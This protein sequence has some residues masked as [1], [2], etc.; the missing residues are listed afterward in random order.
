M[1]NFNTPNVRNGEIFG[2]VRPNIDAHTLGIAAVAKLIEEC[3]YKVFTG[4]A[5]ITRAVTHISK[6]DNISLLKKWIQDHNITRLGFSYRLDPVNAEFY[7][8][9]FVY[10][11]NSHNLFK[12][13]GGT[14]IQIYFAGLPDACMRIQKLYRNTI[15]VFIGDETPIESLKKLGV[16]EAKIPKSISEG[17]QY[18]EDRFSF[19]TELIQKGNYKAQKPVI[20]SG[21]PSY[22]T[23]RDTLVER[24]FHNRR[25][26]NPPLIR[27]H[28]G[29]YN[30]NYED[31]KKEF[32]S[33]LNTLALTGFLDIVSVGSSQLS[34]SHFGMEWGDRANG[35]GVPVNS[36][37]DYHE[38]WESS[39]PMLVRTYSS[40]RNVPD[41][42]PVYERT[43][44]M[45]WHAL[46]FWWFNRI[47][48]R[49]PNE[50]LE[51]LKQHFAAIQRI[52][53]FNK[54]FEPN[55]PHHFS[56]RG[57]DDY[58]YVLSSYIAAK[59]AKKLGIKWFVLQTMLNTP[60]HTWGVQ[61]LA[62]AR[63]LLQ[64]C[65]E[66]EDKNFKVFHQPRAGLDYFS[67]DL[68][69]AKIQLA[70]VTA[71]M[72]D[73]EPENIN[74]PDIIHVVSYCEAVK[75]ATPD[76]IN[77]SIQ[78]TLN[79]LKEYRKL[80]ISGKMSTMVYNKE[81]EGR[82]LDL[83]QEVKCTI[84]ILEK[85]IPNLYTPEG[86]YEIFKKGVFAVPYL[87]EGRD[88]F[89]DAIQWKTGIVKGAIHVL[90]ENGFPLKPKDRLPNLFTM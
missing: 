80:K 51:N 27:V 52:A 38:V 24:L 3:G 18:D 5:E 55:I 75:L 49:G 81:V 48:G 90:D 76:I 44:N 85:N 35:G 45:A 31:A 65:R 84:A 56:F 53:E 79:A 13:Q 20:R 41:M 37:K 14:L 73:V 10:M 19:A 33:W 71:M 87:W 42:V 23:F 46:S 89:K 30:P 50:V 82:T 36:E 26:N 28:V 70:S 78:I 60:K 67:P 66:L 74:G 4:N 39:R 61:D 8:Q 59:T 77:E 2:L 40:T 21:Y 58:T 63:S 12:D 16:P 17:S 64:L 43:I 72:D 57:G 22:G 32:K 11:L 68:D 9:K 6:F 47:D 25:R 88:E 29:P 62:K 34:Q 54:P 7:V 15:P 1:I 86:L 83:Y 69:K